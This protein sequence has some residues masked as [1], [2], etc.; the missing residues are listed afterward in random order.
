LFKACIEKW[1]HARVFCC[2]ILPHGNKKKR[3][4]IVQKI[5]L[6]KNSIKVCNILRKKKVEIA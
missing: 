5:I 4:Q 6:E 3:F 1:S 2:E